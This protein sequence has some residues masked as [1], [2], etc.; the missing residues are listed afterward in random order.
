[1]DLLIKMSFFNP[2]PLYTYSANE[3]GLFVGFSNRK[4][5]FRANDGKGDALAL[6]GLLAMRML[7]ES[8]SAEFN[9]EQYGIF[10]PSG[11]AVRLDEDV[12]NRFIL[13]PPWLGH[14]KL[15]TDHYPQHN[16]FNVYIHLVD[17]TGAELQYWNRN[18]PLLTAK[19]STFLLD[20]AQY[21]AVTSFQQWQIIPA[22][23]EIDNWRLIANL[24][25]AERIG[26]PID[27]RP[28]RE[29]WP[30]EVAMEVTVC[31]TDDGESGGLAL[32]PQIDDSTGC[33]SSSQIKNWGKASPSDVGKGIVRAGSKIVLLSESQRDWAK[34]IL[35][36]PK[37]PVAEKASFLANPNRWLIE[38]VLI[39]QA[40]EFSLRVLGL[41]YWK[42]LPL[43]TQ[44]PSEIDWFD[45]EEDTNGGGSEPSNPPQGK[46]KIVV[47]KIADNIEIDYGKS[48]NLSEFACDFDPD[49]QR[50]LRKP[51]THQR[52]AIEFLL[53]AARC[54]WM[55]PP[56]E[57]GGAL[58][59]DDMGL[60]KTY[61][62]LVF[63]AEWLRHVE[64][65]EKNPSPATLIVA[66]LTL[67][68]NWKNEIKKTFSD[69]LCI[70]NRIVDLHPD[71]D[72]R[73]YRT[74]NQQ[75]DI[76][77]RNADGKLVLKRPA[78]IYGQRNQES[79]D[80][81]GSLVFVTY[82]TLRRYRLS[83][84]QCEWGVVVFDEAQAIKNPNAIQTITAKS[85]KARFRLAMTGTPI[86]NSLRDFWCLFDMAEPDLLK[87]WREFEAKF[88]KPLHDKTENPIQVLDRLKQASHPFMLRRMKEDI[89]EGLPQK[90]VI[91]RSEKR[92]TEFDPRV[93]SVMEGK[94]L[95]VYESARA[96]G[97]S[98]A[99]STLTETERKNCFLSALWALRRATLHPSLAGGGEIPIG[100]NAKEAIR[101]L[102][103]SAKTRKLLEIL[104]EIKRKKEK[105]LI[106]AIQRKLQT[107]LAANL[108]KIYEFY[109]PIINGD[110]PTIEAN[111]SGK[112][113]LA[114]LK[115][116]IPQEDGSANFDKF[117][118]AIL[119]PIAAGVGLTLT[120][121]NHVI[122]L[123]RHWNPAK[124][125][126][127]TDRIYRIGQEKNVCVWIPI[128][129]HPTIA[130][131]DENLNCLIEKKANLHH[132]LSIPEAVTD[133]E[134]FEASFRN[135]ENA[136]VENLHTLDP[137][138]IKSLSGFFFE[139][140]V[141]EIFSREGAKEVIL[142][143]EG[144]DHGCDVIVI[145]EKGNSG[146]NLLIQCKHQD[147]IGGDM[148]VRE[149]VSSRWYYE[150]KMK[151]SFNLMVVTS[152]KKISSDLLRAAQG[153]GVDVRDFSWINE[154]IHTLKI[155]R[156][157]IITREG[158]RTSNLHFME[159]AK[160]PKGGGVVRF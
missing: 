86:E 70:F 71:Y 40:G 28:Y 125:A 87:T 17:E 24:R 77:E 98:T 23:T 122:H 3:K 158:L 18:G 68:E 46:E 35:D 153:Q 61:A 41:D 50:Y 5:F 102:H 117:E 53:K 126:Q 21:A 156:S 42:N 83:L 101:I 30:V 31:V 47:A 16:K 145:D 72:L 85:L 121:A 11:E 65:K 69:S 54:A 124:E 157:D 100:K 140:L 144:N 58:L 108:Q 64:E 115:N 84:A 136:R 34:S 92:F 131:F 27:L 112:S 9:E 114:L 106:F 75:E 159:E 76:C 113:R 109:I 142:T 6:Y 39:G 129:R 1:M 97:I 2:R 134:I 57:G 155:S 82:D 38:N 26:C 62:V 104:E 91:L 130:S 139:A 103:E 99:N 74:H 128:L 7:A 141:A 96:S 33:V 94:Q 93:Q 63:L 43:G 119:S 48:K 150:D 89:L 44:T 146:R 135:A 14:F 154:R 148:P 78:L 8:G 118:I 49:F 45:P 60:G 105:V 36:S 137:D 95:E 51:K 80:M 88:I 25:E 110:T 151:I 133:H 123:E 143:A 120:R 138:D 10:L 66:P 152:A 13:P 73:K 55:C 59:A 111:N 116:F 20:E 147:K 29:E 127:A 132:A 19:K 79:L 4:D 67:I 52:E 149:I 32:T 12:R 160:Y 81:P 15:K 22:K 107:G 90:T 37:V 56:M